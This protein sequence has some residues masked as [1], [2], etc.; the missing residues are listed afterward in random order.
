MSTTIDKLFESRM[1][2]LIMGIIK[3]SLAGFLVSMLNLFANITSDI[4]VGGIILPI[5]TIIRLIVAFFP[6]LLLISA[7]RDLGISI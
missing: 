4:E 2:R 1:G 3:I 6:L 5:G 7:L